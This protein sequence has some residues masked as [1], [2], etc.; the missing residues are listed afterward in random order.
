ML[1]RICTY[2][3]IDP[4]RVELQLY[5]EGRDIKLPVSV[6]IASEEKGSAG[7]YRPP[8]DASSGK[9]IVSI[10]VSNLKDPQK[11]AA[12]IAHELAHVRL[13]G[14]GR[15]TNK[16]EDHEPLTDLATVFFGLGIFN[17]NSSFH[18]N[19]WHES[20]WSGWKAST[21]GYL[22]EPMFGY[23][24]GLWTT[25]RNEENPAWMK[26]LRLNL[27]TFMKQTIRYLKQNRPQGF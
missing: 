22:N 4:S 6:I 9:E 18:F 14:E 3:H 16:E 17:A 13:I 27:R 23:A 12:T 19:Q 10:E 8:D 11:L 1:D 2:M 25:V 24:L 21:L 26:H 7:Q 5:S 20:G 15:I